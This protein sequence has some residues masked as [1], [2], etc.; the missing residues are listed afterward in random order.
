MFGRR[1][2]KELRELQTEVQKLR[3]QLAE[4]TGDVTAQKAIVAVLLVINPT[5]KRILTQIKGLLGKGHVA[6]SDFSTEEETRAFNNAYSR[7]YQELIE[8]IERVTKIE[9]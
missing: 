1:Q 9:D 7:S 2:D 3:L 8:T 5:H 6:V 4:L